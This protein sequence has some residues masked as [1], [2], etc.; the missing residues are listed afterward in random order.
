MKSLKEI[1]GTFEPCKS[2]PHDNQE[3]IK[4]EDHEFHA[5][6]EM[7]PLLKELNKIG[8]R[9]Y[10]HCIGHSKEENGKYYSWIILDM[11][12]I[13]NVSIRVSHFGRRQLCIDWE[14]G[15]KK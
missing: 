2:K 14:R 10:S 6:K 8:L 4:I 11:E 15:D 5:D 3:K 1:M 12:N 13:K 7:I 9:T